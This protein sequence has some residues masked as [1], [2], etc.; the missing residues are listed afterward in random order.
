MRNRA[1][2]LMSALI[3]LT[4]CTP[5]SV[6]TSG[7]AN[8]ALNNSTTALSSGQSI[9]TTPTT[10]TATTASSA[11]QTQA[12]EP[13]VFTLNKVLALPT[14][15][16]TVYDLYVD[17]TNPFEEQVVV[18]YSTKNLAKTLPTNTHQVAVEIFQNNEDLGTGGF[19]NFDENIADAGNANRKLLPGATLIQLQ[20]FVA[21]DKSDLKLTFSEGNGEIHG[22]FTT[23]FPGTEL[24]LKKLSPAL[25]KVRT[26][27][28][29]QWQTDHPAKDV[30]SVIGKPKLFGKKIEL[31]VKEVRFGEVN[32]SQTSRSRP[33]VFLLYNLKGLDKD[34]TP[35]IVT[36]EAYQAGVQLSEATYPAIADYA[37]RIPSSATTIK[38]GRS[39]DL[40]TGFEL[41]TDSPVE[42]MIYSDYGNVKIENAVV[43]TAKP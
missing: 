34:I 6:S 31:T 26:E 40:S 13:Y 20:R 4:G 35:T 21:L 43:I 11:T 37:S 23:P 18:V 12:L 3:I 41:L 38:S 7:A 2:L 39:M 25:L 30:P 1:L 8:S 42:F 17:K 32:F 29:A 36:I 24:D 27:L 16:L 19:I 22:E 33:G 15:E 9:T 28:A 5:S 10:Q 14:Q